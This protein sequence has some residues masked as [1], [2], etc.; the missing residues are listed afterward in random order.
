MTEEEKYAFVNWINKALE[1]DPDC[2]G[3]LP[4]DPNTDA[5]FKAVD[6]GIVL[7]W[8]ASILLV[9]QLAQLIYC[10]FF[11]SSLCNTVYFASHNYIGS[12][13]IRKQTMEFWPL[14][15]KMIINISRHCCF[16]SICS[17][18]QQHFVGLWKLWSD[19]SWLDHYLVFF[20]IRNLACSH[21]S[22]Y[23]PL[24]LSD[25]VSGRSVFTFKITTYAE[26]KK[27]QPT[28]SDLKTKLLTVIY[29][30]S[31]LFG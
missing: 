31:T 29:C 15:I 28:F 10:M 26:C 17:W 3:M 6:N 18:K 2:S 14:S 16:E 7:W 8:V 12:I 27:K 11:V 20:S 24:F 5:L 19:C 30:V 4:M 22:I 21:S 13:R 9:M 23:L 25:V 1:K